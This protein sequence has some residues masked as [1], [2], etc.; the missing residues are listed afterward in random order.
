MPRG[1]RNRLCGTCLLHTLAGVAW[2][3]WGGRPEGWPRLVRCRS[4]AAR[5]AG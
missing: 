5:R 1:R 2:P 3:M 4:C